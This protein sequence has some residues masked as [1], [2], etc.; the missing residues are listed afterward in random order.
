MSDWNEDNPGVN[1]VLT[2]GRILVAAD[3]FD[4][5]QNL[6]DY[7]EKPYKWDREHEL[8]VG[9]DRPEVES[10]GWPW[11]LVKLGKLE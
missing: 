6:L 7:F 4:T 2:F 5:P 3:W 11:F 10:Q 1:E 8:W 9:C